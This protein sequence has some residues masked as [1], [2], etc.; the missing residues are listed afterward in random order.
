MNLKLTHAEIVK[1]AKE[2]N[3]DQVFKLYDD[4]ISVCPKLPCWFFG[5]PVSLI[6]S[7]SAIGSPSLSQD[8]VAKCVSICTP[9]KVEDS[10]TLSS[11][12]IKLCVSAGMIEQAID[13]KNGAR[14]KKLR[15]FQP[16]LWFYSN[17]KDTSA[18]EAVYLELQS[19]A[20]QPGQSEFALM[21]AG[22]LDLQRC[23]AD[24][25]ALFDEVTEPT[26]IAAFSDRAASDSG[27][28]VV[29]ADATITESGDCA[30][31]GVRLRA[32]GLSESELQMLLNLTRRL[33]TE[34]LTVDFSSFEQQLEQASAVTCVIDGANVAHTNQNYAEGFFRFEQIEQVRDHFSQ[35]RA[36]MIVLHRK[37]LKAKTDLRQNLEINPEKPKK[38]RKLPPLPL[39]P[40]PQPAQAKP[41]SDSESVAE[42]A[43]EHAKRWRQAGELIEVPRGAND[44]WFW[45]YATLWLEKQRRNRGDRETVL[46]V[47]NDLMR[48]HVFRMSLEERVWEKFKHRHLCRFRIQYPSAEQCDDREYEFLL[49]PSFTRA[50]QQNGQFWHIPTP[51]GYLVLQNIDS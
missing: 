11:S 31:T 21:V 32:L 17:A 20:I 37:W 50:I 34:S 14:A 38:M 6:A 35:T 30:A 15:T 8:L 13:Y 51:S 25:A 12:L 7:C 41:F 23:L 43:V 42:E 4:A 9:L 33:A 28:A 49:P 1:A 3:Y 24:V 22:G 45:L 2:Q 44:D 27:W 40:I 47:T 26:L 18:I 46:L 36:C 29:A 19:L 48:D 16:L 10:E 5:C 39:N